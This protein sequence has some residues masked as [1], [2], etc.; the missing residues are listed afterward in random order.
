MAQNGSKIFLD[1]D[2]ILWDNNI[3]E[4]Q[5]KEKK[6]ITCT[7]GLTRIFATGLVAAM[8]GQQKAMATTRRGIR[9]SRPCG[10]RLAARVSRT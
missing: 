9:E 8:A 4:S 3:R 10:A 1:T 2:T 7:G 5:E 6:W